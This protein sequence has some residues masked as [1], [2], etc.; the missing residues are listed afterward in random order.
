MV[1]AP[2]AESDSNEAT[3]QCSWATQ[4]DRTN[5][6]QTTSA[7]SYALMRCDHERLRAPFF[8][9]TYPEGPRYIEATFCQESRLKLILFIKV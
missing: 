3:A 7:L 2:T 8:S 6:V 5:R 1:K 4:S 9:P